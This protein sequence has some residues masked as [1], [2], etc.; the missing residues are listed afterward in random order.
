MWERNERKKCVPGGGRGRGRGE[1]R[2]DTSQGGVNQIIINKK[3]KKKKKR[4][5]RSCNKQ[6]PL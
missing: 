5:T 4:E 3:E 1:G 2:V 6:L